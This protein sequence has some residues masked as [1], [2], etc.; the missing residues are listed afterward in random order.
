[1]MRDLFER[2]QAME[3]EHMSTLSRRYHVDVPPPAG[4][5]PVSRAAVYAG[6]ES[7]PGD[8][9]NLFRLAVAFERRAVAYFQERMGS[10]PEGSPE[11][12][13]YQELAAEEQE[14]VALL[15]TEHERWRAGRRG[16]L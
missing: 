14:H 2:F 13:L 11:R 3:R 5:F 7:R 4:S 16:L 1:M 12:K 6:A 9:E 8:P 15:T 10:T